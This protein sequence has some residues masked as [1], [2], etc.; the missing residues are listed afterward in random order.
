MWVVHEGT[1]S[2][3][4]RCT[5]Y[6]WVRAAESM[7]ACACACVCVVIVLT[8]RAVRVGVVSQ[9]YCMQLSGDWSMLIT[10]DYGD[11]A[12][13]WDLSTGERKST[14]K[15]D[16]QVRF[17]CGAVCSCSRECGVFSCFV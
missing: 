8:A 16:G 12:I 11:S 5:P 9:V 6:G 15:A 7:P 3:G 4:P 14:M 17:P 10:G 13:V 2:A 1:L